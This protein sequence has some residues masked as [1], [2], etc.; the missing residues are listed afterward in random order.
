M[1]K[2]R[3]DYDVSGSLVLPVGSEAYVLHGEE[4][5]FEITLRN[6][7]PDAQGHIPYLR[8]QVV[9]DCD[10]IDRFPAVSRGL[11]AAQLD[12][13]SFVTHSTFMIDRCLRVL[14]WE[15]HQ[16]TRRLRPIRSFDP[17][18]PPDPDLRAEL[19]S[20]VQKIIQT[21]P[22]ASILRALRCFR[23]GVI[24]Q[25]PED[26][27][28]QFWLAIETIAEAE[29]ETTRI[30]I[31][32]PKCQGKLF[33]ATCNETPTRRPMARQA[34]RE[35]IQQLASGG[36]D[37]IYRLLVKTRDHLLH[38]RS[39]TAVEV[40]V[41]RPLEQVVNEA[42][43]AAWNAIMF[44]IPKLED[45][46][47]GHRGGDFVRRKLAVIPDTTFDYEGPA[48]HPPDDAIP[49]IDISM[50]VTFRTQDLPAAV[51]ASP[52]P[53]RTMAPEQS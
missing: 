29:K 2:F 6:A 49:S 10:T 3:A 25:Q 36:G 32:C 8:V 45:P 50:Q 22:S 21:K 47:F 17:L 51:K 37:D 7:H 12:I 39:P 33:C 13:L 19:L 23:Y 14:D 20:T 11:L 30:P 9:A 41:G 52:A 38:G 26:Q 4:P 18:Y 1:S 15:P 40:E 5:S 43:A 16:K 48:E 44:S 46:A 28:Q 27:F 34:I 24:Q 42:A 53:S 31:P 35:L